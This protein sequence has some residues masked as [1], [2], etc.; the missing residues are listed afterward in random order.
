M[1]IGVPMRILSAQP[2]SLLAPCETRQGT[3]RPI[4]LALV[5]PQPTGTWVLTHQ[6]AAREVIDAEHA[7]AIA[8]AL[9]AVD[10]AMSGAPLHA[11]MIDNLFPDL[12]NREPQLPPHLRPPTGADTGSDGD[13]L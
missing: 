8:D 2:D 4:D 12:A 13:T 9:D 11:E 10:L 3:V 1:C 5:G 6:G 7:D